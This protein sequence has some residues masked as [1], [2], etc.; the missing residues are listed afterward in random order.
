MNVKTLEETPTRPEN[1]EA[2]LTPHAKGPLE[3]MEKLFTWT[4]RPRLSRA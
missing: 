3:R 1:G 4:R 2:G